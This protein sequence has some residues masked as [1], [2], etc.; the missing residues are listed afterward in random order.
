[1][2]RPLRPRAC[3]SSLKHDHLTGI[4]ELR[5]RDDALRTL[6]TM[7]MIIREGASAKALEQH[8]RQSCFSLPNAATAK[9]MR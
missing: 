6:R 4:R 9:V 7:H 1:M 8:S 3:D 5:V 2:P